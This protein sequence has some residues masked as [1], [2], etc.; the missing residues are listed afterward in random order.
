MSVGIGD[1]GWG[2][3]CVES[4]IMY[5]FS[6]SLKSKIKQVMAFTGVHYR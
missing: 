6:A 4:G 5:V 3:H 1:G 2:C